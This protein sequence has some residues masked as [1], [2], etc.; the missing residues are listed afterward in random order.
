MRTDRSTLSFIYYNARSLNA[1]ISE[2]KESLNM[3][4]MSFDIIAISETWT[5]SETQHYVLPEYTLF[6]TDRDSSRGGGV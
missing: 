5:S 1:N 2:V 3:F 6:Y 4:F